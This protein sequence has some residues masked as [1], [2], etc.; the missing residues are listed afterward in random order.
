MPFRG[1]GDWLLDFY[2]K[3]LSNP[4]MY[5]FIGWEPNAAVQLG[6]IFMNRLVLGDEAILAMLAEMNPI[7]AMIMLH[8]QKVNNW[9]NLFYPVL[10]KKHWYTPMASNLIIVQ[11]LMP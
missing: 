2:P 9:G 6:S 1:Q 5:G 8:N 4:K 10:S 3:A 11:S 7:S